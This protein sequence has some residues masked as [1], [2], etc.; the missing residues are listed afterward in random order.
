MINLSLAKLIIREHLRKPIKGKV[1]TLGRQTIG[2]TIVEAVELMRKEGCKI[3]FSSVGTEQG[4]DSFTRGGWGKHHY[5]TDITFFG[6][7][8]IKDLSSMDVTD[9]EQATIIQNLNEPVPTALHDKFDFIIDGGTF[10]HLFDIRTAF[11]NVVRMLRPDGRVFHWDAASNF[12]GASYLSFSPDLFYDYYTTNDF[13]DCKVY[14][15]EIDKLSQENDWD[16]YEFDGAGAYAHFISPRIQMV[17][18]IAEK[19]ELSAYDKMPIQAQYRET[20]ANHQKV[21]N[22]GLPRIAFIRLKQYGL[23]WCIKKVISNHLDK[24]KV[25]GYKYLGKI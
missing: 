6:L 8:G 1:L 16:F 14:I 25:V 18:V 24:K 5:I 12:T 7:L 3:D 21:P 2:M 9:Y 10:D 19:G 13:V 17:V 15:A 11:E 4:Y 22:I 20:Q 23:K